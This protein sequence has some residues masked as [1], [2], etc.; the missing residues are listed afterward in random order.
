MDPETGYPFY[1]EAP[2]QTDEELHEAYLDAL[3]QTAPP[4]EWDDM[5]WELRRDTQLEDEDMDWDSRRAA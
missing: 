1:D 5:A 3:E 4:I 2:E